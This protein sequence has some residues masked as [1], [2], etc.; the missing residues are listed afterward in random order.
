MAQ[1]F[2]DSTSRKKTAVAGFFHGAIKKNGHAGSS[3]GS[4]PSSPARPL[5]RPARLG[6]GHGAPPEPGQGKIAQEPRLPPAMGDIDWL[7]LVLCL[8]K[9][10]QRV[11][12]IIKW[13]LHADDAKELLSNNL[14][15]KLFQ[16]LA[17][18]GCHESYCLD[19]KNPPINIF[20][21]RAYAAP[22]RK[23]P[24]AYKAAVRPF[25][26][27]CQVK[28]GPQEAQ[29]GELDP[30]KQAMKRWWAAAK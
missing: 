11:G 26:L 3:L 5:L 6:Q 8:Y 23:T 27:D 7:L 28:P 12:V 13:L 17:P 18:H 1:K 21:P 16:H 22:A 14:G 15:P 25:G 10:N 29:E 30:L 4:F 20:L 19:R 9:L 24:Q 2:D